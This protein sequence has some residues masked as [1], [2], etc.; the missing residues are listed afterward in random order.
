RH[1]RFDCDWSS[2][3]CSSDLP[4][5]PAPPRIDEDDR[6]HAFARRCAADRAFL[7]DRAWDNLAHIDRFAHAAMEVRRL[8]DEYPAP[9]DRRAEIGRASCR[10]RGASGGV[11]G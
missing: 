3:V 7:A 9:H 2:D 10:E 6:F 1:T 4:G 8:L 5:A 11:G